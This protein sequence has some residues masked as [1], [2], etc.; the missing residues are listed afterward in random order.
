MRNRASVLAN[1]E[2]KFSEFV[3]AEHALFP[4]LLALPT[5]AGLNKFCGGMKNQA[6]TLEVPAG[7]WV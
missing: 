6:L 3:I 1:S 7:R 5:D 2:E 4:E